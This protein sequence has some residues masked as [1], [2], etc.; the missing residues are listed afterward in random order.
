MPVGLDLVVG[1]HLQRKLGRQAV[2]KGVAIVGG[3][4]ADQIVEQQRSDQLAMFRDAPQQRRRR[5]RQMEKERAVVQQPLFLQR[6]G[7][8]QQLVIVDADD[9]ARAQVFAGDIG[10]TAIQLPVGAVVFRREVRLLRLVVEHRPQAVVVVALIVAAEL[11]DRQRE[12]H[13]IVT[14]V[15]TAVDRALREILYVAVPAEP[16]PRFGVGRQRPA[17]AG[18]IL[19]IALLVGNQ[20]QTRHG[21]LLISEGRAGR[22][23]RSRRARALAA[24]AA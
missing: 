24:R 13:L 22:A 10:E 18:Q 23:P 6:L 16:Q 8:G 1:Q 19:T 15:L 3:G 7:A 20:H 2:E 5:E 21:G 12:G 14:G 9:V 17:G 11:F 4:K